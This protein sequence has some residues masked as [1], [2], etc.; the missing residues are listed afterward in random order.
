MNGIPKITQFTFHSLHVDVFCSH[1]NSGKTANLPI[2]LPL[3]TSALQ[4]HYPQCADESGGRPE[5]ELG[6]V[7]FLPF[8]LCHPF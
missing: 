1:R 8:L 2:F 5:K 6:V 3:L 4:Q 7:L